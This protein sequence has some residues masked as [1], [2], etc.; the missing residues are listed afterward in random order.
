MKG[1]VLDLS[2]YQTI[3]FDCDGVILN[4]NK[5]KT[6]AFFDVASIYGIEVAQ[7]L[8]EYH[9]QNGGI[10]RYAK[11]EHLITDI[12]KKPLEKREFQ[13]LLDNFSYE[14][15]QA[16]TI[17]EVTKKLK[18]LRQKTKHAN[19][20]II[21]GGDQAEIR[22]V[23]AIRGLDNYFDSGI[24]G[25]PETKSSILEREINNGN[26]S[27]SALFIGDSKY[28]HQVAKQANLDFL[29]LTDWTE[30]KNWQAWCLE[31][32]INYELNISEL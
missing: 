19:W 3:V 4:S 6:Q 11:F 1:K 30:V 24:F 31:N 10:S 15:K 20:L 22:E 9:I 28:D 2:V 26:I 8:K 29:F 23:F 14:V 5:I 27:E 16:L 32:K 18:E 12:L 13:Q 25:S 21:T 7:T 17:C